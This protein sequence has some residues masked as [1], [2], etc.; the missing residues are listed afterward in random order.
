MLVTQS[1]TEEPPV[2]S[3]PYS[4]HSDSVA[5]KIELL[6]AHY[7]AGRHELAI[8]LAESLK[9]TL[10]YER[11][12][13]PSLTPPLLPAED[14]VAVADLPRPIA[15][16]A[17]GWTYC[18]TVVLHETVGI[19]R[20]REP[21]EIRLALPAPHVTDLNREFRV[22]AWDES[23]RRLTEIPSQ[24]DHVQRHADQ[25]HA[26]VSFLAE[27]PAHASRHY[28]LFYGNPLAELP[29][30]P[31]D[32]H[33]TGT[34]YALDIA[35]KHYTAKLSRQCGQ[36]ER[37]IFA[38]NHGLELY[39]GG[40]GHGEP[41]GIDWG[42]DYVDEGNFQ[43]LRLRNGAECPNYEI[44]RGPVSVKVRRWGFP[45]SPVHPLFTPS[46]MHID[47][48]YS[49]YSGLPYFF[50]HGSME[51][52]QDLRIEA[53]RDDEWVFTGY[54]FTRM[55]WIDKM[56][57]LQEGAVPPGQENDLWG[58]GFYNETSRDLFIAL[59]LEHSAVGMDL[60]HGGTPN[61]HYNH[62]GQLWSR[63]PSGPADL[64]AGT[65]VLQ[66]NAYLVSPWPE[67][68]A[69]DHIQQLRHQ[70]LNPLDLRSE[71]PVLGN[72]GINGTPLARFGET[73]ET[74]PL[75]SEIW[76]RLKLV[77]D[78]QLYSVDANVVDMGY[79]YDVRERNG[80]VKVILTMP[81]PGR[82]VYDFLVFQGGGRVTDGIREQLLKIPG[83]RDVICECTWNPAWTSARL[84]EQG[85]A[86]MKLT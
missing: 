2:T 30:Y 29:E 12:L 57:R 74:A 21:V 36:I 37:I 16:W 63:Y 34:G 76:K 79:I 14:F 27:V 39:A 62:H 80:I 54:S 31:T 49:F 58:V 17:R 65:K 33:V 10:L 84:T 61:M 24:V 1:I 82:G 38:Y 5:K 4:A 85:R 46:R 35:S 70:L 51:T 7:A 68:N 25:I 18:K 59:R 60:P 20:D 26:Q 23:Q 50:K 73:S 9:D 6:Q 67:K 55:L 72:T 45:Y 13:A 83:V 52:I 71:R 48:T 66:N 28:L 22:A 53:M 32:L 64:K 8:A 44:T 42:H 81:T 43:K 19:A 41:P 47:L 3:T 69:T 56:G 40:K 77:Q 86:S 78:E 15:D 75:K 11:Q